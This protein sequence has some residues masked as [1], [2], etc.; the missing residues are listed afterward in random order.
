MKNKILHIGQCDKF[1]PPYVIFIKENY[2]FKDHKFFISPGMAEDQLIESDNIHYSGYGF[3]NQLH[4]YSK[5]IVEMNSADKIILHG[6]YD[7]KV[8]LIL[9]LMPWLLKKS[10][11]VMWGSDLYSYRSSKR[12]LKYKI[13]EYFR[14]PVIK[15]FAFL[16][17]TV[18][19]D[20]KLAQQWYKTNA[21]FI[22]NL[23]YFSHLYRPSNITISTKVKNSG[24]NLQIGNSADPS[25]NHLEVMNRIL[26]YDLCNINI[27]CPLSYGSIKNK[28]EVI[29]NGNALF[30][31]KFTAITEFMP[32]EEYN[33]YMSSIDVAIF[34]HNRQQA[35]GNIIA[36]LGLGKKVVLKKGTT[37][38]EFLSSLG[39]TIYN[40]YDDNLLEE[41]P[42]VQKAKNISLVKDYFTLER[43]KSNWQEVFDA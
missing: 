9:Y 21:R 1:I 25:N 39:L 30:H 16:T 26:K 2:I 32:F 37:H 4:H 27:F 19:G 24:I 11:W 20:Y 8:L 18:P 10:C 28:L 41:I 12:N 15:N 36:L 35:M 33:K 34:N 43:L 40:L 29:A 23:M 22:H 5:L 42:A 38:Y 14:R 31:N 6:L 3:Q 13:K 7:T 17:T